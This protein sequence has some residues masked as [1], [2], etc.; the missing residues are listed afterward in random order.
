MLVVAV[1]IKKKWA[2]SAWSAGYYA[3]LDFLAGPELLH[4]N[5]SLEALAAD[6]LL[7]IFFFVA[8]LELFFVSS[9]RRHTSFKCD[10]SSDVCSSDLTAT[11]AVRRVLSERSSSKSARI[12]V[13]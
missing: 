5:L 9:R 3:M 2:N 7:A 1:S 6:G 11:S 8:G 4:L 13:V 12:G 10:W